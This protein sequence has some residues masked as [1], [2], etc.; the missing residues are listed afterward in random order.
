MYNKAFYIDE[1]VG[2][3]ALS[4][5]ERTNKKLYVPSCIESHSFEDIDFT[6]EVTFES[7]DFDDILQSCS[8]LKNFYEFPWKGKKIF[9]FD[10]HN[11]AYFFWYLERKRGI[12]SDD[13]LLYHVDEHADTRDP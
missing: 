8:G 6:D 12:I 10:N 4:Y 5:D 11:H 3:N 1:A 7:H 13:T 9:L 2:N